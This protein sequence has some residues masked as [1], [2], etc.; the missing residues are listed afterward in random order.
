MAV[1]IA[2]AWPKKKPDE[3]PSP[4]ASPAVV[5]RDAAVP[6]PSPPQAPA[7][8]TEGCVR[9]AGGTFTMGYADHGPAHRVTL[10]GFC[11]DRTEV[12]VAAYRAC[13]RA[14]GGCEDPTA[15]SATQGQYQVFCNW[16]RSDRDDHPINCVT[17]AQAERFCAWRHTNGHLPTE[18]QWE[19]AARGTAGRRYPWGD[20][21]EPSPQNTNL[22]GSEC[23]DFA[24]TV[25]HPGWNSI[26][27]WKDSWP[28]TSAVGALRQAGDTPDGLIGMAGNVWEWT[29]TPWGAYP[30]RAGGATRHTSVD[31]NSRVIRGGGW[32]SLD[33]GI[34]RAAFRD[35]LGATYGNGVVGF[36]C[37]VEE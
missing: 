16:G 17:P 32:D 13:V 31:P 28:T 35:Q 29:R 27:N 15:S 25:G 36:R 9:L 5:V 14:S 21:P 37:V 6:P 2:F 3:P 26:A 11:I 20:A 18:D 30:S 4:D 1:A 22:C 19:F 7:R 23:R 10:P 24:A 33:P 8:V 12:T 34:A